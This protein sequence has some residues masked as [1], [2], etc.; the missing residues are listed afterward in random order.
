MVYVDDILIF[1]KSIDR[2]P[3]NLDAVLER[4]SSEGGS[5]NLGK[6]KFLAG[7][8]CLPMSYH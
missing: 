3:S 5:I 4:I 1:G 6:S 8:N 2:L 7:G